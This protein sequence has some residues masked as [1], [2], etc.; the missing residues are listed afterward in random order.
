[1]KRQS[2]QKVPLDMDH[3]HIT[4]SYLQALRIAVLKVM[5]VRLH[6]EDASGPKGSKIA[7]SEEDSSPIKVN[8]KRGVVCRVSTGILRGLGVDSKKI[9]FFPD[10]FSGKFRFRR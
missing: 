1:M 2:Q 5:V 6:K 4:P 3:D 9:S 8:R 7:V 10:Q